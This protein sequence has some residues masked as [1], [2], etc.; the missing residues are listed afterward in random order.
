MLSRGL[1]S[2]ASVHR[3]ARRAPSSALQSWAD[4]PMSLRLG[5]GTR[6]V[7]PRRRLVSLDDANPCLLA[8]SRRLGGMAL[9]I[10]TSGGTRLPVPGS[11]VVDAAGSGVH[12][13]G[14]GFAGRLL[15]SVGSVM[16]HCRRWEQG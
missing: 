5:I 6:V 7:S 9:E 2:S 11:A 8:C 3:R 13:R 12:G 4:G 14:G 1:W 15:G 10:A 16:C